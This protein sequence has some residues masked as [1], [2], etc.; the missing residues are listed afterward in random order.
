[1]Y[2]RIAI[3]ASA[4][5]TIDLKKKK[6]SS[7]RPWV[8]H[9]LQLKSS[10]SYRVKSHSQWSCI[11][12]KLQLSKLACGWLSCSNTICTCGLSLSLPWV[13]TMG[14]PCLVVVM[15]Q[16]APLI[17]PDTSSSIACGTLFN[18]QCE[19][20]SMLLGQWH[21]TRCCENKLLQDW[22]DEQLL[23]WLQVLMETHSQPWLY[24]R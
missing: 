15:V 22:Y 12:K 11:W 20:V 18:T 1:M 4:A 2:S 19:A 14:K 3:W 24:G 10:C 7:S 6:N 13:S 5:H 21:P 17:A 8:D 9:K 16:G 23:E